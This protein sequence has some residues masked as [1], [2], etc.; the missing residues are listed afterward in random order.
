MVARFFADGGAAEIV[1][2]VMLV[3]ALLLLVTGRLA[4]ATI[5][6]ALLPGALIVLALRNALIAADWP[7]IALPLAAA[8]PIHLADIARRIRFGNSAR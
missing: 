8:L 6:T 7:W 5:V 1:L 2:L 4:P 3:E